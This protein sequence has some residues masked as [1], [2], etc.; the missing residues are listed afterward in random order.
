MFEIDIPDAI[1]G[2]FEKDFKVLN[3]S[4]DVEATD[5]AKVAVLLFAG[6]LDAATS[7]AASSGGGGSPGTGWGKD[8]DED[9]WNWARRCAKM[10]HWMCKPIRRSYKR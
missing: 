10:A 9:E 5:Y 8:K 4:E 7:M 2:I 3:S 6:Y 1:N